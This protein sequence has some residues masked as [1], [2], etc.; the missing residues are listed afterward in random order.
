MA[1]NNRWGLFLKIEYVYLC[2]IIQ[3]IYLPINLYTCIINKHTHS[4]YLDC[5]TN[6]ITTQLPKYPS[7]WKKAWRE[8][9]I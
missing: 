8:R 4:M 6:E 2:I 1:N 9:N 3:Y 7:N 5:A